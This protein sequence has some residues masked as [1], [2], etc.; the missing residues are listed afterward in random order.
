MKTVGMGVNEHFL[1]FLSRNFMNI[2]FIFFYIKK[3][4]SRNK[5]EISYFS[6]ASFTDNMTRVK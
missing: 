2:F 6:L 3:F 1:N 5:L 4:S